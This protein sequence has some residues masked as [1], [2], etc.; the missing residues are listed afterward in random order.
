MVSLIQRSLGRHTALSRSSTKDKAVTAEALL[1][2]LDHVDVLGNRI[3]V[4]FVVGASG[5]AS[6]NLILLYEEEVRHVGVLED[7]LGLHRDGVGDR[8]VLD[9]HDLGHGGGE[10]S[11]KGDLSGLHV[12]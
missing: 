8:W 9:H 12:D 10:E 11:R 7:R 4:V 5:N 6:G 2:A 1:R 3:S